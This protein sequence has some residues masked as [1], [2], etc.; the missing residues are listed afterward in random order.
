MGIISI[1]LKFKV[2]ESKR[3]SLKSVESGE[4]RVSADLRSTLM[5]TSAK[6]PEKET[7]NCP[8]QYME[9]QGV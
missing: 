3:V 5:L 8:Q 7:K 4:S 6:G 2:N 1:S 9:E